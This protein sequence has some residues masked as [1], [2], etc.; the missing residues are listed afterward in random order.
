M[1][2]AKKSAP[3]LLVWWCWHVCYVSEKNNFIA[4]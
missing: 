3:V 4:R 1:L 2:S